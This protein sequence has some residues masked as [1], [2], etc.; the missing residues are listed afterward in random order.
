MLTSSNWTMRWTLAIQIKRSYFR[1]S[2]HLVFSLS[3]I[4]SLYAKPVGPPIVGLGWTNSLLVTCHLWTFSALELIASYCWARGAL[5]GLRGP[6]Q[7][8]TLYS[9]ALNRPPPVSHTPRFPSSL[10]LL[11]KRPHHFII[12]HRHESSTL[13]LFPRVF[14]LQ[15]FGL[16]LLVAIWRA[17]NFPSQCSSLMADQAYVDRFS[18]FQLC[19][20]RLMA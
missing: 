8:Q 17:L 12:F 19:R 20:L 5:V 11:V 3:H 2:P 16:V 7:R 1:M 9:P 14:L 18:C 4:H 6:R 10:C 13:H 15:Y